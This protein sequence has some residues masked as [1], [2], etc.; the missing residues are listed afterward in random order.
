V[1]IPGERK[2]VRRSDEVALYESPVSIMLAQRALPR[3]DIPLPQKNDS[4]RSVTVQPWQ[5]DPVYQGDVPLPPNTDQIRSVTIVDG[6][7][8]SIHLIDGTTVTHLPEEPVYS[9]RLEAAFAVCRFSRPLGADKARG[10][11]SVG[12][13]LKAA[14]R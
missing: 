5:L 7:V 6:Q 2:G 8:Y 12:V 10:L 14:T 11:G 4:G 9:Y 3:S 1:A 13:F